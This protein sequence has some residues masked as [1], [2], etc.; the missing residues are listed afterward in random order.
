MLVDEPDCDARAVVAHGAK[1]G[2]NALLA[3]RCEGTPS[4]AF[5]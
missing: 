3:Q 2:E 5:A 4:L 1:E